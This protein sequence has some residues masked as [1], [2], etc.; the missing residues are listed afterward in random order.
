MQAAMQVDDNREGLRT[1]AETLSTAAREATSSLQMI[2]NAFAQESDGLTGATDQ[3]AVRLERLTEA[4][5]TQ[6]V[7]VSQS[8]ELA[9]RQI[10][11]VTDDLGK[12][13]AVITEAANNAR[14]IFDGIVD[15]VSSGS[16]TLVEALDDAVVKANAVGETFDQQAVRLTQASVEASEQASKLADQELVSRR[17]LFLKTARF[18]I[19]D[20]NST[21]IDLTRILRNDVPESN[22]KRYMKG[23]RGIFARSLLKGRQAALAAK[24]MEKLKTDEDMRY[25]VM[26]YV[27]QFDKLLN[28]ARE[29][30][31]EKLLHTTFMTADVG[32]LYI[33]LTRAL[34]RHE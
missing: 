21:S 28:D 18:I 30:D 3:V 5:R 6:A 15:K 26:R 11:T 17:D 16:T 10:R 22:W 34:G 2:G 23:D 4:F 7:A 13:S 14:T 8:G 29:S 9:N 20:L 25:Y 27:D 31:P 19:E 12:Q 24:V 33:L 32:K 1:Q